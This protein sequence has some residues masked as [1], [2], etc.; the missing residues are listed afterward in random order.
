MGE[1]Q[2][3]GALTQAGRNVSGALV[4][5]ETVAIVRTLGLLAFAPLGASAPLDRC[6]FFWSP[7]REAYDDLV[8]A[9]PLLGEGLSR[10]IAIHLSDRLRGPQ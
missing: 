10:N 2:K 9:D 7:T 1:R 8:L 4:A 3:V 5:L 6:G